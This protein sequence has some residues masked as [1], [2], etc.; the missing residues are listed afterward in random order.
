MRGL[1]RGVRGSRAGISD[2]GAE[3]LTGGVKGG[4]NLSKV[5]EE[6]ETFDWRA[7]AV[8]GGFIHWPINDRLGIQPEVLYSMQGA[9]ATDEGDEFTFKL[10][11]IVIPILLHASFGASS[12]GPNP[13]VV[14]GP[15]FGINTKAEVESGGLTADFSDDVEKRDIGILFGGGVEISNI[16]VEGRYTLGLVN[17]ASRDGD[18]VR[19]HVISFLVGFGF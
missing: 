8:V 14:A 7:G 9:K 17:I 18:T 16:S 5:T 2:A 15:V 1:A 3:S 10:D 13:F 6:G 12:D 11:Y 4:L 19:N